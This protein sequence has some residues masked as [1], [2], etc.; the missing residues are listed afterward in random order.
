MSENDLHEQHIEQGP[1]EDAE[2][3]V[4]LCSLDPDDRCRGQELRD[5]VRRRENGN[6]LQAIDD[7]HADDGRRKHQEG[8]R[9]Q[10]YRIFYRFGIAPSYLLR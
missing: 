7:Q 4:P 2:K 5:T 10:K 9:A 3:G 1:R 6:I 8:Q